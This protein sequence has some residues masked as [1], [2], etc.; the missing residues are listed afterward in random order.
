M[1][2]EHLD[3]LISMI[4]SIE[5]KNSEFERYLSNLNVIS[6]NNMI[7]ELISDIIRNNQF[8]QSI[9]LKDEE[10]YFKKGE[11]KN[12]SSEKYIEELIIKIQDEP[13]KKTII[14]KEFLNQLDGISDS[15][16]IVLLKS[17]KDK[18]DEELNQELLNLTK[19]FTIKN[20]K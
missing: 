3:K 14:L 11:L 8:F 16:L 6:R 19:I 17:L 2:K 9:K 18:N 20:F 4:K 15:D 7:K 5:K 10:I 13:S 1:E 12:I